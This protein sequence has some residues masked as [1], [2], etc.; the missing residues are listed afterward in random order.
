MIS[1]CKEIPSVQTYPLIKHLL[2]IVVVCCRLL[3]GIV[4]DL[5]GVYVSRRT[6][7]IMGSLPDASISSLRV[8]DYVESSICEERSNPENSL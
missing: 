4:L 8:I 5:R 6:M 1:L 3:S 2:S 7:G